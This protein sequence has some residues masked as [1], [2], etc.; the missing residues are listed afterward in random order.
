[1]TKETTLNELGTML[2]YVIRYMTDNM[3]TKEDVAELGRELRHEMATKDQ[4][5]ALQT[6][7]SSIESQLRS[8]NHGKLEVRVDVLEEE[9]FGKIRP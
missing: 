9:V 7:V 3:A 1:M 6:Q 4:M 8:E 5:F 2:E